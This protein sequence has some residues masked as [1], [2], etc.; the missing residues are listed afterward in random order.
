M[1]MWIRNT[2]YHNH[3]ISVVDPDP[4]LFVG[5]GFSSGKNNSGS[6]LR[7]PGS[8]MNLKKKLFN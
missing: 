8:V 2:G 5:C 4:I 7:Q 6:G 3:H 1:G